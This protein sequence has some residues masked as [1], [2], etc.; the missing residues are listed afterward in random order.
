ML[1]NT[2]A[3][4]NIFRLLILSVSLHFGLVKSQAA[5]FIETSCQPQFYRGNDR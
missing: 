5:S 3:V 2:P 4:D 1:I